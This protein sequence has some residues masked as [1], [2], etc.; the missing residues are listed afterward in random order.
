MLLYKTQRVL[1]GP[2]FKVLIKINR[3]RKKTNFFI[4][5]LTLNLKIKAATILFLTYLLRNLLYYI[6]IRIIYFKSKTKRPVD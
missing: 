4:K 5:N 2:I 1:S 3:N 6:I